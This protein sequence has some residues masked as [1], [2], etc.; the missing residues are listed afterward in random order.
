MFFNFFSRQEPKRFTYRPRYY[1]PDR[2]PEDS[3]RKLSDQEQFANQIH[4]SWDRKR[5]YRA[6]KKSGLSTLIWLI[7]IVFLI[8]Y[9]ILN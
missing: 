1:N 3:Q 7:V 8:L 5:T 2:E 6:K 9:S 4:N